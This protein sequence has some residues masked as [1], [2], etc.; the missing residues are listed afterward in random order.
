MLNLVNSDDTKSSTK[1]A[2]SEEV[3]I[4][5]CYTDILAFILI[6]RNSVQRSR[7]A[8]TIKNVE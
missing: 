2:F 5:E 6:P 4:R 7:T 3:K 8:D 1:T